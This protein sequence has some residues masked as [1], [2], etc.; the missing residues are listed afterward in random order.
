MSEDQATY[1]AA[2]ALIVGLDPGEQT[3]VAAYDPR[4]RRLRFCT[5]MSFW[6]AV[7]WFNTALGPIEPIDGLAP[8]PVVLVVIE[9]ARKLPVYGRHD[10]VRGRRRDRLARNIGGIDRDTGLWVEYLKRRGYRVLLVRPSRAQ[11]KWSAERF[12]KIT[13]YQGRT[14]QHGRDAARLVWGRSGGP[15]EVAP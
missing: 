14:S 13:R 3:G 11:Q 7:Q 10:K 4:A 9:D 15:M 5:S 12:K 2:P 6:K 8:G 1:R